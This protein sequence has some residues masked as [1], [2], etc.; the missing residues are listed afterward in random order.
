VLSVIGPYPAGQSDL[1]VFRKLDGIMDMIP[2]GRFIIGDRGYNGEPEKISTPNDHD[3]MIALNLKNR[4][5]ARHETFNARLKE[6]KILDL[7]FRHLNFSPT[8]GIY[9]LEEHKQVFESI[10]IMIQYDLEYRPLF[11]V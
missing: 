3:S 9:S 2:P 6:F 5:R 8:Q 1:Q 11:C 7:P 10:C 4:A